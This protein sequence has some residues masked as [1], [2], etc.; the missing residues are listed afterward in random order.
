MNRRTFF[1]TVG[2]PALALPFVGIL[3]LPRKSKAIDL[4]IGDTVVLHHHDF[5]KQI[6]KIVEIKQNLE[7][8]EVSVKIHFNDTRKAF[9]ISELL[10]KE[11]LFQLDPGWIHNPESGT[12]ELIEVSIVP[13]FS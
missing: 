6:G 3:K 1:K 5:R 4:S 2:I 11:N 9:E 12:Y 13:K 7:T 8:R 10:S